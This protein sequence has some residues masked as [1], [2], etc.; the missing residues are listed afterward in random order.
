MMSLAQ[1]TVR[2]ARV[3]VAYLPGAAAHA[4]DRDPEA[5]RGG[6]AAPPGRGA[7]RPR[8]LPWGSVPTQHPGRPIDRSG[9]SV[10]RHG[11]LG[12]RRSVRRHRSAPR[13]CAVRRGPT[14]RWL[15]AQI[16]SSANSTERSLTGNGK[17]ST[18]VWIASPGSRAW[19]RITP[20][21]RSSG[22]VTHVN[23]VRGPVVLDR[24]PVFSL[25]LRS[26]AR[27][28]RTRGAHVQRT[29]PSTTSRAWAKTSQVRA[30]SRIRNTS[31]PSSLSP[32]A[33]PARCG[34]SHPTPHP[35]IR[36]TEG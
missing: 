24:T 21:R 29:N 26:E 36:Q 34:L 20:R 13:H 33:R 11:P 9:R 12:N 15:R 19:T 14:R 32:C 25:R 22:A 7:R 31:S 2:E 30:L 3:T 17:T 28:T 4:T 6:V 16:S 35:W 1:A 27:C 18:S 23:A 8:R 10:H 5:D